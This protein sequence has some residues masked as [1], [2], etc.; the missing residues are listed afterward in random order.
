MAKT[1]I[2]NQ[3]PEPG[4]GTCFRLQILTSVPLSSFFCSVGR[5]DKGPVVTLAARSYPPSLGEEG[6]L[7]EERVARL[8]NLPCLSKCSPILLGSQSEESE[9]AQG[10]FN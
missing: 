9:G 5:A 10:Q 4:H 3:E 8:E 7:E 6:L 2:W 1:K